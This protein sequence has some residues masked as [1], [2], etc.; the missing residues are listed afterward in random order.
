METVGDLDPHGF[1]DPNSI[2]EVS[3]GQYRLRSVQAGSKCL[4]F[5]V[6]EESLDPDHK[7][8]S[9]GGVFGKVCDCS[10]RPIKGATCLGPVAKMG[11]CVSRA[12]CT[13]YNALYTRHCK[14]RPPASRAFERYIDWLSPAAME[15]LRDLYLDEKAYWDDNWINKWPETK[16]KQFEASQD[17]HSYKPKAITGFIK[18]EVMAKDPVKGRLIQAYG[19]LATQRRSAIHV[20]SIQKAVCRFF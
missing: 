10:T 15:R 3:S 4:G 20:T 14:K 16:R 11:W 5:E 19:N 18:Y 2:P 1:L 9:L 6:D 8:H 7:V 17:K 12:K 13:A